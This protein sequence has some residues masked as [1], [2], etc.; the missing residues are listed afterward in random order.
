MKKAYFVHRPR[1]LADLCKP[2][3]ME[4]E[5]T[6]QVSRIV[7][8]SSLSYENFSR[9]LLADRDFLRRSSGQL[10]RG[11]ILVKTRHRRDGIL[12]YPVDAWVKWAAYDPGK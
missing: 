2:H 6:Y 7:I 3:P 9:D 8:L 11:C 5:R 10:G 12:V 4:R 1:R